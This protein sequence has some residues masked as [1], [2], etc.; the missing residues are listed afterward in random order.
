MSIVCVV[1]KINKIT[2]TPRKCF[3]L[4]RLGVK[5]QIF[6]ENLKVSRFITTNTI[7]TNHQLL[8]G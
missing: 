7:N 4:L 1:N 5:A 2:I 3:L 8:M 6:Q